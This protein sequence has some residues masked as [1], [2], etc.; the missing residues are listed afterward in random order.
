[1][2]PPNFRR[3]NSALRKFVI[4]HIEGRSVFVTANR[5][6]EMFPQRFML[7]RYGS[8]GDVNPVALFAMPEPAAKMRERVACP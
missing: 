1:M 7:W 5:L 8:D 4:N 6:G 2:C 3:I